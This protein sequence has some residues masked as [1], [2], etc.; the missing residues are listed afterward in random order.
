MGVMK[1]IAT[2]RTLSEWYDR[3]LAAIAREEAEEERRAIRAA[4]GLPPDEPR[5]R[6]S[7]A[8]LA[9]AVA[10]PTEP[11]A[12]APVTTKP[13]PAVAPGPPPKA[14]PIPQAGELGRESQ[15]SLF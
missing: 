12:P 1:R 13:V 11:T 15:G 14:E 9:A 2:D 5:R 7:K 6:K 3:L 8:E 10:K 4:D